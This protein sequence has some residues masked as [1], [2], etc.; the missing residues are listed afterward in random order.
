VGKALRRGIDLSGL[1]VRRVTA[2]DFD[3]FD[4]LLS[5]DRG[6]LRVLQALAPAGVAGRAYLFLHFA[7]RLGLQDVPDP[8]YGGP[9]GFEQVLVE[10][11]ADG[12]LDHLRQTRLRH[13]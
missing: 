6:H 8:Y 13:P 12:L 3:R 1:R 5:M 4:L 7:P 2:G 10:A 11:A 9:K